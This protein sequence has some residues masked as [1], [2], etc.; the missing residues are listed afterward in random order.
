MIFQHATSYVNEKPLSLTSNA[1]V[2][3][4]RTHVLLLMHILYALKASV[5]H[6]G[7]NDGELD[8]EG[9]KKSQP[10]FSARKNEDD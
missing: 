5:C 4:E 7:S 1:L 8:C 9:R 2:I 3:T 6:Y 10:D